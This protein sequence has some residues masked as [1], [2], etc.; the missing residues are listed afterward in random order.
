MKQ[1]KTIDPEEIGS[2]IDQLDA[3]LGF[4]KNLGFLLSRELERD[5]AQ[6]A[7]RSAR[8]EL[9]TICRKVGFDPW[10]DYPWEE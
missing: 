3:A 4:S 9:L 8:E 10:G 2:V 1:P 5:A 7:M 6:H